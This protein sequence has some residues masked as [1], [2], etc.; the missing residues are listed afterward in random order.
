MAQKFNNYEKFKEKKSDF[1]PDDWPDAIDH[2]TIGLVAKKYTKLGKTSE[3]LIL[4]PGIS[5]NSKQRRRPRTRLLKCFVLQHNVI[6]TKHLRSLIL[7]F[8]LG[9]SYIKIPLCYLANN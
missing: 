5:T 4:K 1:S 2:L 3:N 7:G 8:S 9:L 6:K